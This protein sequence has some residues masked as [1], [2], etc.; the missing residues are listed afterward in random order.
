MMSKIGLS[1]SKSSS[2][3]DFKSA[4]EVGASLSEALNNLPMAKVEFIIFKF[5]YFF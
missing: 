4:I 5:T 1:D 3:D 2:S